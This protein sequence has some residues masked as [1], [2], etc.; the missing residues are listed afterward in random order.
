MPRKV[1]SKQLQD[2]L[3]GDIQAEREQQI[4]HS[5]R[6]EPELLP[7]LCEHLAHHRR[8]LKAEAVQLREELAGTRAALE[9]L[10]APPLHPAMVLSTR[11]DQRVEILLGERR[12]IIVVA[13]ELDLGSMR[14]GDEVL[15]NSDLTAVVFHLGPAGRTGTVGTVGE[16]ADEGVVI[17]GTADEEIVAACTAELAGQLAVG[18]RVVLARGYPC[19]IHR[20]PEKTE[21]GY[22]L[23]APPAVTFQEIGGLDAITGEIRRDLDLHF[24]HRDRVVAYGLELPGGM[25]FVGPPGV[26][27]TLVAGAIARY[28]EKFAGDAKFLHVAPGMFRS[29]WY[30]S[31]EANIRRLF[32]TARKY[33][34][35]VVI[36]LDELD[37]FG[38]RGVGIGQD[39]DGRVLNTL[40]TELDG[41]GS[42]KNVLCIGATNRLDLCDAALIRAIRMG[43]R[44]YHIP[45]PGRAAT[46]QIL[47]KYLTEDLPYA[48]RE[49]GIGGASYLLEV[50]S[51]YLHAP[52]GGAPP[53]ATATFQDGSTQEIRPADVL[54]GALLASAVGRAKHA[55]AYRHL[56]GG[57]GIA[58]EDLL[59]ALD[60]ALTA[61]ARKLERP[62]V[63]VQTLDIPRADEIVRMQVAPER[64]LR[65]HRYLRAA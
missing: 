23:E 40:L 64:R 4:L 33:P 55:A 37:T 7:G 34:G 16:L 17:R 9:R 35:I 62:H 57:T 20:L 28:L 65:R 24:I 51:T 39:I 58:T 44:I 49:S 25:I 42:T 2:L 6:G 48:D 26:G 46:R 14:G 13:P 5:L 36:F 19:V 11:E 52:E 21:S 60:E 3:S 61:E 8:Q 1:A 50:A 12:Q 10:H 22:E 38:A 56:D 18:D 41:L 54:S 30:G 53:I 47:S 31:T 63:A 15:V 27:K 59:E 29:C 32:A 45:R 43:E